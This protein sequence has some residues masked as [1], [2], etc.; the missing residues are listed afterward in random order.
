MQ[1]LSSKI[2]SKINK[3]KVDFGEMNVSSLA[4]VHQSKKDSKVIFIGEK[5][6]KGNKHKGED[7]FGDNSFIYDFP[8]RDISI[9]LEDSTSSKMD[10]NLI[11][12]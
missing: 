9:V 10:S 6:P 11:Y 5:V 4:R 1:D 7:D 8:S 3:I 2:D 12:S